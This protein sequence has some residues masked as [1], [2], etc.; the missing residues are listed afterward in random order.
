SLPASL[1]IFCIRHCLDFGI[2]FFIVPGKSSRQEF[3]ARVLGKNI[4]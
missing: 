2:V 1:P 4:R 3:S